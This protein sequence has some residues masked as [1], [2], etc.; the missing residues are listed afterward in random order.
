MVVCRESFGQPVS[1]ASNRELLMSAKPLLEAETQSI[2]RDIPYAPS[3]ASTNTPPSHD[4]DDPSL[5]QITIYAGRG[6]LIESL[7]GT[8]WLVGTAVEHHTKYQYQFAHTRSI[9]A[10]QIQTETAYYQP[11]PSAPLPFPY[12]AALSDPQ[13]SLNAT[14]SDGNVTAIPASDGW[15]LRI[16]DSS[17]VL[18][19]GAGLYSFF[20]N[21]STTCSDQGNGERCQNRIF[22]LE[23]STG[24]GV[25]VY[26]LNTVGTHY[27]IAV[28]GKNVAYYGDNLNGFIDTV[29]LFRD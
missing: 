8:I 24:R 1:G 18:I 7:S 25:S 20:D 21:Y 22:S 6:L 29:A 13:F 14:V 4:V 19:Y 16:L 28:D 23:Q 15:G 2:E 27:Q 26:N 9:F 12:N 3:R 5:T 11:N 10:G 17:N